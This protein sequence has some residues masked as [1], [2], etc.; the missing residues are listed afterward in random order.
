ML[1]SSEYSRD[2]PEL[3][4]I[5][6]AKLQFLTP[7][8]RLT[9]LQWYRSYLCDLRTYYQTRSSYVLRARDIPVSKMQQP[10]SI[11]ITNY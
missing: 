5:K 4:V 3:F 7:A 11:E 8:H 9:V 6:L 2:T 10:C 1:T